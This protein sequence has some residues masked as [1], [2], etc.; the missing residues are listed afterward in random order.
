[1][2]EDGNVMG[3]GAGTS[4]GE[5]ETKAGK[6]FDFVHT[7]HLACTNSG[8]KEVFTGSGRLPNVP[9][10][11]RFTNAFQ[12]IE[13]IFKNSHDDEKKLVFVEYPPSQDSPDWRV[14]VQ[15]SKK[16]AGI[17]ESPSRA[18]ARTMASEEALEWL[19]GQTSVN[20]SR[21]GRK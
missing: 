13:D 5:A 18:T 2:K 16:N 4:K 1:M 9:L 8:P 21:R 19:R 14:A 6:D 10:N 15:I 20:T 17:G 11:P 3:Y 7:K 12:E